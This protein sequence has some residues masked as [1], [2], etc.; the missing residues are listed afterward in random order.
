MNKG[1]KL[2][3]AG[4]LFFSLVGFLDATYL[5]IQHYG[6]GI[7]PCYVFE[8]CDKVITS[9][10][11]TIKGVP[12]SLFGAIYYLTVLASLILFFDTE[13]K[14]ILRILIYLPV[15]GFAVSIFLLFLQIFIIKAICFYCIISLISS[16]ALFILGLLIRHMRE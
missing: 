15:L 13:N 4:I 1:Q 12:I 16:T 11:A 6:R 2:I 9:S 14:K 5:T 3:L 8:G 10:Y 7:L